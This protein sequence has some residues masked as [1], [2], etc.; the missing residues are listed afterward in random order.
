MKRYSE[1][2]NR[3]G[4]TPRTAWAKSRATVFPP[5]HPDGRAMGSAIRKTT[6]N[7]LIIAGVFLIALLTPRVAPATPIYGD[8]STSLYGL[9]SFVGDLSYSYGAGDP[10]FATLTIELTNTSPEA[11]GGYLGA[12]AFLLPDPAVMTI[13]SFATSNSDFSLYYPSGGVI[14]PPYTDWG[15]EPGISKY[16]AAASI[17][18]SWTGLGTPY[19]G[20]SVGET[21]LFTFDISGSKLDFT[22][23]DFTSPANFMAVHFTGFPDWAIDKVTALPGGDSGAPVPEPGTMLLLGCGLAGLAGLSR[24]RAR[25]R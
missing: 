6:V 13:S 14:A 25:R 10:F 3:T 7:S 22:S 8:E 19:R 1:N 17:G 18:T 5:V 23:A 4:T 20:I 2:N 11:N 16:T 24:K 9:G 12:L 21:A 15:N